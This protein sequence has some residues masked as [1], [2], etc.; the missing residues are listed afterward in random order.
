MMPPISVTVTRPVITRVQLRCLCAGDVFTTD[1]G[2]REDVKS[3]PVYMVVR[4]VSGANGCIC[5]TTGDACHINPDRPV[6]QLDVQMIVKLHDIN[7]RTP[8]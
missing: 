8:F 5:L 3:I 6:I 4:T 1:T 7:M 2:W